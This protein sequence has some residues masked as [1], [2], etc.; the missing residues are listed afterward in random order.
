MKPQLLL[1][2]CC[3]PDEAWVV[4]SLQ[5]EY[6]LQC[7]FCNPNITPVDEYTL[8]LN[9][10]RRVAEYYRV[11][12]IADEYLPESWEKAVLP[13]RSTPEGGERCSHCFSLRLLRSAATAEK[14]GITAFTTVMSISPHKRITALNDAGKHAASQFGISYLPFDFKKKG[15][16]QNSIKLS[17]ELGLYRQDYCGCSLSKNERDERKRLKRPIL[18][19]E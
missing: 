14:L 18:Q 19:S 13:Y 7:F 10:A 8:R 1:H 4:Q 11:P 17:K 15:G 3:A 12:F 2:I 16:F 6:A 9:E 5:N